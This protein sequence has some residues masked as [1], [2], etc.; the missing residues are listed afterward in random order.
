MVF[1][2]DS[3]AKQSCKQRTHPPTPTPIDHMY[4]VISRMGSVSTREGTKWQRVRPEKWANAIFAQ[5]SAH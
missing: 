3:N 2:T 5:R 4:S 1:I